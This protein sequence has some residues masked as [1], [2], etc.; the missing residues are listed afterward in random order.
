M[1]A[2]DGVHA[3]TPRSALPTADERQFGLDSWPD[4][5]ADPAPFLATEI[6]SP[7]WL[8]NHLPALAAAS[9]A[10]RIEGEHVLHFDVRSDNLCLT[11][12]RA[13]FVDWNH[14]C[15]GNP[16]LDTASWLPSLEAEGG[17]APEDILA[18]RH[19]GAVGDRRPARRLLLC[20]GRPA[21][22]LASAPRPAAPARA[23][24][25]GAALGRQD[26]GSAT[27]RVRSPL[28][29][30]ATRLLLSAPWTASYADLMDQLRSRG[31]RMTPQRRA[32][33]S[34]VMRRQGPHLPHRDRPQGPGRH[35][36]RER[37]DRVPDADAPRERR[38]A[39]ALPRRDR[40]RVPP[41]RGSRITCTSPAGTAAR[42]TSCHWRKPTR[43]RR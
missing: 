2:L 19:A 30:P 14:A 18:T 35:A 15:I 39:P 24:E 22:D 28:L 32:I 9:A 31:L 8:T 10:A 38:R 23:G 6:C 25:D 7:E 4:V 42:T 34:E 1:T 5:A 26:A 12:G 37:L 27:A 21:G 43:S 17:P 40:G 29:A 16:V 13:L 3:A 11:E 33:V 20:S 36:G 41:R